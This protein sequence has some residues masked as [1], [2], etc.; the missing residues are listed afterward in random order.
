MSAWCESRDGF[1]SFRIDRILSCAQTSEHF[2]SEAGKTYQDYIAIQEQ[3]ILT[4]SANV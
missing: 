3:L 2:K 4:N 1:R